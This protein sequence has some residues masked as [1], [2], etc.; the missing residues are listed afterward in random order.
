MRLVLSGCT[1]TITHRNTAISASA[2]TAWR[3]EERGE[4]REEEGKEEGGRREGGGKREGERREGR[5][6]ER[7]GKGE[8]RSGGNVVRLWV[9]GTHLVKGEGG[10]RR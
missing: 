3:R 2:K 8:R 7:G 10:E 1:S 5:R 4:R 6:R 9:A